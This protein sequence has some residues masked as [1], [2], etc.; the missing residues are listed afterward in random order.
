MSR[1]QIRGKIIA[2]TKNLCNF[3]GAEHGGLIGCLFNF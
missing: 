3:V 1:S 2:D